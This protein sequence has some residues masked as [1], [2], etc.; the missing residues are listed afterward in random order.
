MKKLSL[1]TSIFASLLFLLTR[2]SVQL[3]LCEESNRDCRVFFD[4]LENIFYF[5][6]ILLLFSLITYSLPERAFK[7]WLKFTIVWVPVVLV[8]TAYVRFTYTGSGGFFD[9]P[10]F[11]I[12]PVTIATYSIYVLGSI[13]AII[14]NVRDPIQDKT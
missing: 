12:L 7:A 9:T 2:Y 3:G 10:D 1:V 13:I 4:H 5:F 8:S 6:P 11:I 14:R